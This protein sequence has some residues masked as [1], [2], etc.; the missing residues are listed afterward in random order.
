MKLEQEMQK[1]QMDL[2]R[3][4]LKQSKKERQQTEW[5]DRESRRVPDHDEDR[6]SRAKRTSGSF[7]TRNIKEH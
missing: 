1:P 7:I 6:D 2:L 5:E 4:D 3:E